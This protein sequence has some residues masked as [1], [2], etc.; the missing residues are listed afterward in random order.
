MI[1]V[2]HGCICDRGAC[3]VDSTWYHANAPRLM[4]NALKRIGSRNAWLPGRYS[5]AGRAVW[6]MMKTS[7]NPQG[8]RAGAAVP[9]K[10]VARASVAD[11]SPQARARLLVYVDERTSEG[12][13]IELPEGGRPGRGAPADAQRGVLHDPCDAARQT[14]DVAGNV[15]HRVHAVGHE[16]RSASPGAD[17]D[18][19]AGGQAF[20]DHQPEGLR[21]RARMDDDVER[22]HGSR[23]P[24]HA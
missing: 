6:L 17:D 24:T 19:A 13:G 20:R 7:A 2:I 1:A 4:A 5:R 21:P 16:L 9:A 23:R 11:I 12:I 8:I 15:R 10:A 14:V 3:V 18:G 22:P